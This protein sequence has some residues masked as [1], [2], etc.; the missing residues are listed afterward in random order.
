[1]KTSRQSAAF[2]ALSLIACLPAVAG[3]P[4]FNASC[5]GGVSVHAD[6]GGPV[7]V[8]GRETELKRFN[9]DYFEARD[10]T[11][12]VALSISRNPSGEVQLSYTGR[13]GANGVC[14][15]ESAGPRASSSGSG[16]ATDEVTCESQGREQTECEMDT[17]GEVRLVR[18]LSRTRCEQGENWGLNRHSVWVKDGCRAVFAKVSDDRR[19]SRDSYRGAAVA[20]ADSTLLG[21]CN[22]RADAQGAL[23]TR[24]AVNAEVTELIVDYPDGRFLCMV[25]NDGQVQSLSPI[26]RK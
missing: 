17:R 22:V 2:G 14:T 18:Q 12:G 1:M 9:D 25:R 21:A 4:F 20:G 23:V 10:A 13:G 11:S 26:R 19:G 16:R 15:V 5:P 8:N 6:D 24:V 3:V 7:F